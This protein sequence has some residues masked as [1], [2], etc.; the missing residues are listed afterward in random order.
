T[1]IAKARD[2][3]ISALSVVEVPE[4]LPITEGK[5]FIAGKR[6]ILEIA[7][8]YGLEQEVPVHIKV[9]V[10]HKPHM[11]ILDTIREDKSDL[12]VMGWRGYTATRDKLLGATLD[13]LTKNAPCDI[14]VVKLRE[15]DRIESIFVPTA[16]GPHAQFAFALGVEI[17]GYLGARLTIGT[18]IPTTATEERQAEAQQLL[19]ETVSSVA[20]EDSVNIERKIIKS[21]SVTVALIKESELHSLTLIGASNQSIWEQMRLGSV[22][23]T[24]SRRS[25]KSVVIVRKYEGPIKSWA[26]RFFSG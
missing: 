15:I 12:V 24:L 17:A 1:S 14:A 10:T 13:P 7:D 18:I 19:E 9:R 26:R 25:P 21:D 2:G 22:P 8:K 4:Q 3:D 23:E 6:H 5:R 20:P 11:G 16:G